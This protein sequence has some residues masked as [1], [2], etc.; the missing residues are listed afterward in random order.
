MVLVNEQ[1]NE[2]GNVAQ[3]VLVIVFSLGALSGVIVS[4]CLELGTG[5]LSVVI[6]RLRAKYNL[7]IKEK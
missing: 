1:L 4:S 3:S 6:D 2:L 7:P 5:L